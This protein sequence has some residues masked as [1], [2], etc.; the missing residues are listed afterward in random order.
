[1][2]NRNPAMTRLTIHKKDEQLVYFDSGEKAKG[3]ILL[4][5]AAQTTLT[6]FFKLNV[7]NEVGAAGKKAQ[8]LLY[9]EIPTYF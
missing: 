9:N 1:M 7:T 4:G 5:K 3:Q 2:S 6:G 8:T